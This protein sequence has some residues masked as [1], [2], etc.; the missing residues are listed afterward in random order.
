MNILPKMEVTTD[1]NTLKTSAHKKPSILIPSVKWSAKSIINALITNENKPSVRMVIGNENSFTMGLMMR[2]IIPK[3]TAKISA[4]VKLVIS[5][6]G[7][8]NL[9]I[10]KAATAV[11]RSLIIVFIFYLNL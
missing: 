2:L 1:N 11:M 4:D 5:T 3:T 10:P 8:N 9:E 6:C 7:L